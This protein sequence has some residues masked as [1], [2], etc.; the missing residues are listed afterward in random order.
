MDIS[1]PSSGDII[2]VGKPVKE[3]STG[4]LFPTLCNGFSLAGTGVRIKYGFVKVYAVGSYF[5]PANFKGFSKDAVEKALLDP[6]YPRTIRIVM[7][8]D[9]SIQKFTDALNESL[10]PR[11]NGE[12]LEKLEEF[13]KLNPSV[14]LI[15]GAEMELTIRGDTLL[16]KNATGAV[17]M[18][19]SVVF[20]RALCDV[21]FGSSPVSP[22][23]K[24]GTVEGI[25]RF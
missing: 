2:T 19:H 10:K 17:G 18:I 3:K 15:K 16:Y 12:D 22:A 21:Y 14:D 1:V 4:I 5:D 20:T 11:M 9:L 7:A 25:A 8:R 23:L 24:E 6:M 13:R